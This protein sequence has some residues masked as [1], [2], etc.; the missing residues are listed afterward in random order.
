MNDIFDI[1]FLLAR[2]AAGKSEIL[3]YLKIL[4]DED[5]KMRFHVGK[6]HVID[7][8]PMLWTWFEEDDLLNKMGYP[9]LHTDNK[10]YFLHQY[11]WNILI[12]RM[13]L[14][15]TKYL[16]DSGKSGDHTVFFE[17]SRGK[18]HGGY[19]SAFAHFPKSILNKAAILYVNVSWEES[20]RK[21]Q[22]RFNP[23]KPD[24]ILEHALPDEKLS[25]LYRETDWREIS[26]QFLDK[27]QIEQTLIP[28]ATFENEDDITSGNSYELGKRLEVVL[29]ELWKT[30]TINQ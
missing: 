2:P 26:T 22:K 19:A 15:Y 29:N 24:S 25:R 10:G 5:R 1:L 11:Q 7:D 6:M 23:E 20:L 27:I 9:R 17:F 3:H 30:T 4:D 13:V 18:E 8:F 28:Y 14:E 21:N 12:E 16:R